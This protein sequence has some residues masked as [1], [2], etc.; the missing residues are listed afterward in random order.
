MV[1]QRRWSEVH[2]PHPL[3]TAQKKMC[4][5]EGLQDGKFHYSV[6]TIS[7]E[8][9]VV[10]TIFKHMKH[11]PCPFDEVRQMVEQAEG[12]KGVTDDFCD[13]PGRHEQKNAVFT[14][15]LRQEALLIIRKLWNYTACK[16]Q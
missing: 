14:L 16:F 9:H 7:S 5:Y 2:P 10:F 4:T 3:D 12:V 1:K 6:F 13:G 15:D 11:L 8:V